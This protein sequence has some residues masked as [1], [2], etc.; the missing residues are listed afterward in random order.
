MFESKD[1]EKVFSKK[2]VF[3]YGFDLLDAKF[4]FL[5]R[6]SYLDLVN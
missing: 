3:V 4:E 2:R 6:F 1:F 5:K